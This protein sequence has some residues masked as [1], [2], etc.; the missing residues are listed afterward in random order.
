M[1]A[2]R[3]GA[4]RKGGAAA[5]GLLALL[6]GCRDLPLPVEVEAGPEPGAAVYS[7]T[8]SLQT[9]Q[10]RALGTV[11]YT[12]DRDGH[13]ALALQPDFDMDAPLRVSVFLGLSPDLERA[14]KV[15]D[16]TSSK[17]AQRWT[18]WMPKGAIWTW[19]ILWSED[20]SAQVARAR[21]YSF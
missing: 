15:G 21:L 19:V 18:F 1:S 8:G 17:G 14:V 13:A 20:V 9:V 2:R 6:A 12:I 10:Y 7:S 4:R 11:A 3:P 16:V 5:A